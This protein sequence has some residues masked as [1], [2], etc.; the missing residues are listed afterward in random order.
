MKLAT[1]KNDTRDGELVLINKAGTHYKK[2]SEICKNTQ[3]LLDNWQEYYPKLSGVYHSF[4][5]SSDGEVIDFN[6]LHSPLPRSYEWVDG[7]AYINHVVLVRKA[8]NAEPP[9]TLE[10]DPLV[11][12]GGSGCFLA[13][14]EDIPLAD[15]SWGCDFES[16]VA[17]ILDDI[18]QG[19]KAKD[20]LKYIRLVMI[21]NDVS[22]RGLIPN[23]LQKGFGFFNSKPSSAFSPFAVTP[24]EIEE[25]WKDGRLHLPM[26]TH[27]NG[28]LF[29]NPDAG[30]EMFFGFGELIEH[31]A[32]TRPF[33]AGTILGSGTVSNEDRTKGSSCLAEKRMIEKIDTGEFKTPFMSWGDTVEIEVCDSDGLSVF[34]KISQKVVKPA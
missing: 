24:D 34:G 7:S 4:K 32:K 33:T 17:V 15:E 25:Y 14:R 9:A 26:K 16:E 20:A 10:T 5:N 27:Y 21:C 23:E 12:Q 18:P 13:P 11:Y 28:K 6:R 19:T 31:I 8:R 30:P 1:L 3:T 22:L 2:V 29:G